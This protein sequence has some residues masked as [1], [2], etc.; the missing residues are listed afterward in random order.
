MEKKNK[1]TKN[2]WILASHL[3]GTAN[4]AADDESRRDRRELEWTLDSENFHNI[5]FLLGVN[6][7]VDLFASRVNNE[8]ARYEAWKPYPGAWK[9]DAF[10]VNWTDFSEYCFPPFCLIASLAKN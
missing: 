9:I 4:V 7:T 8:L 3:P 10:S 6:D 1:Q 5:Q 2:S